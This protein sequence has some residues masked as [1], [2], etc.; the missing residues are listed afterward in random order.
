MGL[1]RGDT[2]I[3]RRLVQ[4][5]EFLTEDLVDQ[6]EPTDEAL[7]AYF[8]QNL[9][10]YRDPELRTFTHIYFS[11]DGLKR[12]LDRLPPIAEKLAAE[13]IDFSYHNSLGLR[14]APG[15]GLGD[16]RFEPARARRGARPGSRRPPA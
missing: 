13:G 2:I 6:L 14:R 1:E 16:R 15:A 9:E 11:V 7:Q 10:T 5:I 3:R 4:K 12:F 8:E